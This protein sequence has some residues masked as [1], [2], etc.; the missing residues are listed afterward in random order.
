MTRK[1]KGTGLGLFITKFLV[2]QHGGAIELKDNTP[3]GLRV[4]IKFN[5]Q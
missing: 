4:I 5:V 2:E 1:S 3:Q